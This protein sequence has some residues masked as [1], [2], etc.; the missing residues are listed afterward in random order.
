MQAR[1]SRFVRLSIP[2]EAILHGRDVR[3][4]MTVCRYVVAA[5]TSQACRISSRCTLLRAR[6]SKPWRRPSRYRTRARNFM[7][8]AA[9][10]SANSIETTSPV[11]SA[12]V[13]VAP[14]PSSPNSF[15]RPHS[16][17]LVPERKTW[18]DRLTLRGIGQSGAAVWESI[19]RHAGRRSCCRPSSSS[20]PQTSTSQITEM[21]NITDFRA[22]GTP[23]RAEVCLPLAIP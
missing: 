23:L 19:D 5:S 8:D 20:L 3:A 14:M 22:E 10:G 2:R 17:T 9:I 13:R 18:T 1:A 6:N 11:S 12:P 21:S 4:H 15:E 7:G 16:E